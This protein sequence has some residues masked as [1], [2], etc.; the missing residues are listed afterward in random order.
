MSNCISRFATYFFKEPFAELKSKQHEG[1]NKIWRPVFLFVLALSLFGLL[2]LAKDA[3]ISGDEFFHVHHSQDVFN[4]YK[5][6]E[7]FSRNTP[8]KSNCSI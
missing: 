5:T 3:G 7:M 1:E 2:F 4:Y 8:V 6:F